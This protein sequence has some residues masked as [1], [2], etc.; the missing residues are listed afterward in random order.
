MPL[1]RIGEWRYSST[2]LDLRIRWKYGQLQTLAALPPGEK[3]PGT[4]WLGGWVGPIV[5]LDASEKS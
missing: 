4:H 1:K 3:A 5:G 2:I